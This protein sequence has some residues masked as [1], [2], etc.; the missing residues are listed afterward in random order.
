[1]QNQKDEQTITFSDKLYRKNLQVNLS[2]G[3][4][5]T[6]LANFLIKYLDEK[7]NESI[8]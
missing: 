1:M 2:D 5:N 6:S 8:L 3:I 4:E 7:K